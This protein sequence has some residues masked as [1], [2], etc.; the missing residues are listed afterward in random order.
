MD[1]L[2]TNTKIL[3]QCRL[4][5][6][7]LAGLGAAGMDEAVT[8]AEKRA[9]ICGQ[10]LRQASKAV[11]LTA[12]QKKTVEDARL[13]GEEKLS[14]AVQD[15]EDARIAA[16]TVRRMIED[17]A[18][19][20]G[21]SNKDTAKIL[22]KAETVLDDTLSRADHFYSEKKAQREEIEHAMLR[23]Y[24]TEKAVLYTMAKAERNEGEKQLNK[25]I[26][27]KKH[28]VCAAEYQVLLLHA[29][30]AELQDEADSHQESLQGLEAEIVL[31]N[32]QVEESLK[33]QKKAGE[34][35]SLQLR[36]CAEEIAAALQ[37]LSLEQARCQ[38]QHGIAESELRAAKGML[39]DC[40]AEEVDRRESLGQMQLQSRESIADA[41]KE[42]EQGLADQNRQLVVY[43]EAVKHS[44]LSLDDALAKQEAAVAEA[45]RL[46]ELAEEFSLKAAEAEAEEVSAREA[47]ATANRLAENAI[48][49][50]ES[51]S[52][53]S[54]QLLFHAQEV[55]M[56]AAA[57][58]QQLM[59]EKSL[60]RTAAQNESDRISK[61]AALAENTVRQAE[62]LVEIKKADCRE[63]DM[64]LE[65][66]QIVA[67]AKKE[68][69]QARM[70]RKIAEAEEL[71]HS[72]ESAADQAASNVVEAIEQ[73]DHAQL[74][75]ETIIVEL[76]NI[77][78][79]LEEARI[80]GAE[81]QKTLQLH[82]DQ[83]NARLKKEHEKALANAQDLEENR[84]NEEQILE[85]LNQNI[86]ELLAQIDLSSIHVQEVIAKGA[87]SIRNAELEV[88]H[89]S[90]L[91]QE[92]HAVAEEAVS[93]MSID[94]QQLGLLESSSLSSLA[95]LIVEKEEPRNVESPALPPFSQD[96]FQPEPAP[97]KAGEI[98]TENSFS[99]PSMDF[100][101]GESWMD[102]AALFFGQEKESP[103]AAPLA[104]V[105]AFPLPEEI[106]A[107]PLPPVELAPKE[108]LSATELPQEVFV[109]PENSF[110]LFA[111][112]ET[113]A[114]EQPLIPE[115]APAHPEQPLIPE[116]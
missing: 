116:E 41:H 48:K 85:E 23:L 99:A 47:A 28:E 112:V 10:E 103:H 21:S 96:A 13:A 106:A 111:E 105:E 44:R 39:E 37:Q 95:G 100:L 101:G 108:E 4:D 42:Y 77:T 94:S 92:A 79:H 6:D 93:K 5:M 34:D 76:E 91:E 82:V 18:S 36:A 81:R 31:A 14:A 63:S 98:Y 115:E 74:N 72:A 35:F 7:N 62:E 50:R 90:E 107:P 24:A 32:A 11:E 53:E 46:Q 22:E 16:E 20:R 65:N 109:Q 67:A 59:D 57:S 33:I 113:L 84:K 73:R 58:A 110:Q 71:L 9:R 43:Q 26:A 38:E 49:I 87:E 27:D 97:E 68:E 2:E 80:A 12:K 1:N 89:L 102:Q 114:P 29:K 19:V 60:M 3:E 45:A 104:G 70:E 54:S 78:R 75:L 61:Q 30:E 15:E 88:D 86:N 69:L 64:Q 51:I 56:E 83:E 55:L 8:K 52:S 66:A 17:A 40:Q 25:I